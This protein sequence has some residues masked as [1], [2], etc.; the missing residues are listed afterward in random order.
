LAPIS[1][2]AP[3]AMAVDL[4]G[5]ADGAYLL[6]ADLYLAD[7]ALRRITRTLTVVTGFAAAEADFKKRLARIEGHASAQATIL[8]PFDFARRLDRNELDA[9]N[10]NFPKALAEARRL[11]EALEAGKGDGRLGAK[12]DQARHYVF[13]EGGNHIMPYRLIV[14]K[15]YDA[16][17]PSRLII[18]LHG[19]GGAEST[20]I[21]QPGNQIHQLAD[22][23]NTIVMAPLGY[24]NY[25]G[26]GRPSSD[27]ARQRDAK[28]SEADALNA[29]AHTRDEYNIDPAQI[30]L[31]G[32]SMGANGTWSLV[33]KYP[34]K[35]AA[36]APISAGQCTP[37]GFGEGVV[38][39]RNA[40]PSYAKEL[41]PYPFGRLDGT[42][43]FITHGAR[44]PRADV[45][46]ARAMFAAMKS[47]NMD[48]S[49]LENP[50]GTHAMLQF[51]LGPIFKF[52][53]D[54][55]RR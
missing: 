13:A 51:S 3:F 10:F 44:D 16:K 31:M 19:G 22:Q 41:S 29:I 36:V 34:E 17:I 2:D 38:Q 46:N 7:E 8:Y 49:Y 20:H 4:A 42:P 1:A 48:V 43:V 35:W 21:G 32:H 24:H 54:V 37:Q 28:L 30:F 40:A 11:L 45:A 12:G 53:D 14:P 9:K 6:T 18:T 15:G 52:F 55:A 25:G 33:A 27:P 50:K 23:Y 26:W 47:R 5:V 39:D